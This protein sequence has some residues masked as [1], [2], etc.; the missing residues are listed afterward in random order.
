MSNNFKSYAVV[1]SIYGAWEVISPEHYVKKGKAHWWCRCECGKT[2]YVEANK[3]ISGKSTSC[4]CLRNVTHGGSYEAAYSSWVEMKRRCLNPQ[5]RNFHN[6]GGRG[7]TV[8]DRWQGENGYNNF[9]QDM[10]P[11]PEG[12]SIDRINNDLGYFPAN[13]RWATPEEQALNKRTNHRLTYNGESLTI[14]EWSDKLGI[15]ITT[16][17][18]RITSGFPI[19]DVLSKTKLDNKLEDYAD[20]KLMYK[21]KV[22]TV[23]EWVDHFGLNYNTVKSRMVRG[24]VNPDILFSSESFKPGTKKGSKKPEGSGRGISVSIGDKFGKLTIKDI[25]REACG[26]QTITKAICICECGTE[27][28]YSL[29][30]IKSG[31]TVTCGCSKKQPHNKGVYSVAV[32]QKFGRLT[33][34]NLYSNN[35]TSFAECQCDC[36]NI[37]QV[38]VSNLKRGNTVSCGCSNRDRMINNN[39]KGKKKEAV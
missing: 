18:K 6:Y 12:T 9:I 21:G 33:I 27:K 35:N 13:C 5:A 14:K 26:S 19:E 39:P 3:L 34:T 8:C 16:I 32:G 28:I 2:K 23:K 30:N 37:K 17:A 29:S 1:G 15:P 36:G 10:G 7:I 4:G 11:R 20:R 31:K 38:A 24:V 22:K 25:F